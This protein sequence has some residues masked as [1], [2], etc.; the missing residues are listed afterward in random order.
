M[1]KDFFLFKLY[2]KLKFYFRQLRMYRSFICKG[3]IVFD[4]GANVGNRIKSFHTLGA[5]VIAFE[6]QVECV[7]ILKK[8]FP[9]LIIEN[10]GLGAKED[11]LDLNISTENTLSTF[12]KEFINLTH[13]T[14][15]IGTEWF[16]KVETPVSTLDK[17][18][19]KYGNPAFCK[20]DTEGYELEIF[21]GLSQPLKAFSFEYNV[22]E[23]LN[24]LV[25]CLERINYLNPKYKYNFSIGE[26]MKMYS[27]NWFEYS[28]FCKVILTEK[29]ANSMYGDIYVR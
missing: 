25:Q 23:L 3:D 7:R 24:L 11:Y 13:H 28:E 8:K 26:S 20:I 29:F 19:A 14:R 18:I 12:S 22:P 15:F 10:I 17:M 16:K 1:I 27:E 4:V 9:N 5:R 2:F 6:P 21:K